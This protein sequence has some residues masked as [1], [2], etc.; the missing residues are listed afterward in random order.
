MNKALTFKNW[1]SGGKYYV[2]NATSP[3][4]WTGFQESVIDR[5]KKN[6]DDDFYIVIWSDRSKENDFYNIPFSKLMHLFTDEHKTTGKFKNRWTAVIDDGNFLMHANSRLA[7]SIND[8]YGNLHIED[9]KF[10]EIIRSDLESFEIENEYFEGEEKKRLSNYYERNPRLR[11]AAIKAHGLECKVCG[12][13]F[14][15]VYGDQGDGFIEV[16]HIKPVSTLVESKAVCP[17]N[18]MTVVCSNCHRMLHRSKDN[19]LTV[20]E[21][22]RMIITRY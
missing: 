9:E 6:F 5:L 15:K 8:D 10:K 20:D 7:V 18:D 17:I 11:I 4:K 21:L 1:R 13:N 22:K 19:I 2:L 3:N 16:H 12:I 14:R